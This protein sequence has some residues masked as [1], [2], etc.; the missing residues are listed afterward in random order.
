MMKKQNNF[1]LGYMDTQGMNSCCQP[2][3]NTKSGSTLTLTL[4]NDWLRDNR[5]NDACETSVC[6]GQKRLEAKSHDT[7]V[8]LVG[9]LLP[10]YVTSSQTKSHL[11][12]TQI[13]HLVNRLQLGTSRWTR[14][15]RITAVQAQQT[16]V[17]MWVHN[18]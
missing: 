15:L 8:D 3:P 6:V 4:V 1:T 17:R 2:S 16:P 5:W 13:T 18:Q 11:R 12:H 14:A 7:Q 9:R 10:S